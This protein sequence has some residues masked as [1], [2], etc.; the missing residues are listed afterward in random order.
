MVS[1]PTRARAGVLGLVTVGA[2]ALVVLFRGGVGGEEPEFP[3]RVDWAFDAALLDAIKAS[4]PVLLSETTDFAW[5]TVSV[6][7]YG[8]RRG[9]VEAATGV[10]ILDDDF[11]MYTEML[12]VFCADEKVVRVLPYSNDNLGF[13]PRTT[14]SAEVQIVDR[15]LDDGA[16]ADPAPRCG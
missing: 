12:L 4:D 3:V 1:R 9:T 7:N 16:S 14:F 5:E 2:I 11:Y 13:G 15:R 8:T 6:F 10:D